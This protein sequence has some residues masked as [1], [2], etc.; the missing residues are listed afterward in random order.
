MYFY[1]IVKLK[2]KLKNI[3]YGTIFANMIYFMIMIILIEIVYIFAIFEYT[4][5]YIHYHDRPSVAMSLFLCLILLSPTC[6]LTFNTRILLSFDK[7]VFETGF[8]YDTENEVDINKTLIKYDIMDDIM[9]LCMDNIVFLCICMICICLFMY[10]ASLLMGVLVACVM[11]L[12]LY[13]IMCFLSRMSRFAENVLKEELYI[14]IDNS[15]FDFKTSEKEIYVKHMDIIRKSIIKL[16][17][18]K[19]CTYICIIVLLFFL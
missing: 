7:R 9:W 5:V 11:V 8:H 6:A 17:C 10:E 16:A 4:P 13:E 12:Y 2:K 15:K 19:M 14:N 3:P 18:V 1:L